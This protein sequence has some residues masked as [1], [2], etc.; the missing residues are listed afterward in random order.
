M[1]CWSVIPRTDAFARLSPFP[2]KHGTEARIFRFTRTYSFYTDVLRLNLLSVLR[3]TLASRPAWA[4][5]PAARPPLLTFRCLHCG[6]KVHQKAGTTSG[7]GS[8]R[9]NTD[10]VAK[11]KRNS[12][13]LLPPLETEMKV[14]CVAEKPSIA[15][16]LAEILNSDGFNSRPGKDKFCRNFDLKYNLGS[17]GWVDMTITSVRGHLT[18]LDFTQSYRPWSNFDPIVL[19]DAPVQVKVSKDAELISQ[20]LRLEARNAHTLMIWTDCD[21]EGEHIGAEIIRECQKANPR[22]KIKRA[23]FSA[24][25]ANQI[26]AACRNAGELDWRAAAAVEARQE[27]DLR[28]GAALTRLQTLDIKRSIPELESLISYG[29]CQFPTLGFVV[30]QYERVR[31]FVPEKFWYVLVTDK[32]REALGRPLQTVDFRWRRGHLFD[33]EI[34]KTFHNACKE[35]SDA[36]VTLVQTKPTKKFKPYPLTTVELQKSGSRLLRMAPKKI[37]DVAEKLYNRGFLSYPRTETDQYDRDF[38]FTTLIQ[39]QTQDSQWGS[40]A[41][42]LVEGLFERPRDGKKNDKAHPPIHPTAH[43]S[44]LSGDEAKV[45]E[46]V[47]R[48][49][50]G[51]CSK[52]ATGKQTTVQIEL[53]DEMFAAS[54]LVIHERNYLDVFTYDK[55]T[56]NI[57][58]EYREGETFKPHSCAMKE[59][60]TTAPNYLTEADLVNLMDKNG[61]GTDA[62]IAEHI[63]KVIDREYVTANKQGKVTYLLPSTLGQG[64]VEGYNSID[65]EKSLSKPM[66]RR[67]TEYRMNL[68]CEGQRTKEETVEESIAEYRSVYLQAKE[69]MQSLIGNVAH[70]VRDGRDSGPSLSTIARPTSGATRGNGQQPQQRESEAVVHHND[71]G[72]NG[73]HG[74]GSGGT[75]MSGPSYEVRRDTAS[76]A[77]STSLRRP[78]LGALSTNGSTAPECR[79]GDLAVART[80]VKEGPNQGRR[81]WSCAKGQSAGSC[82]FFDWVVDDAT[83]SPAIVRDGAMARSRSNSVDPNSTSRAAAATATLARRP[84]IARNSTH[85]EVPPSTR[86]GVQAMPASAE[87]IDLDLVDEDDQED[88]SWQILAS[89]SRGQQVQTQGM[90]SAAVTERQAND[91]AEIIDEL[92]M[93]GESQPERGVQ[94][95]SGAEAAAIDAYRAWFASLGEDDGGRSAPGTGPSGARNG[96]ASAQQRCDCGLEAIVRTVSKEGSNQGRQFRCCPKESNSARCKYFEWLDEVDSSDSVRGGGRGGGYNTSNPST[97]RWTVANLGSRAGTSNSS[98]ADG[99][100]NGGSNTDGND[101]CFKCGEG[102]HWASDCPF[103]GPRMG[104]ARGSNAGRPSSRG[105][106]RGAR[107]RSI[108]TTTTRKKRGGSTAAAT[109]KRRRVSRD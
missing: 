36:C 63:S 53:A 47:T 64:L 37:L 6:V 24:I 70:R 33:E 103:D 55:W 58:P 69:Q 67:E 23:R 38:N 96:V 41:Q 52:D 31:N 50:L 102:G 65:F 8:A 14:L 74:R 11:P 51:S 15:K 56:G 108:G 85:A 101:L 66:L 106:G 92:L 26:H 59:G 60:A 45:Y 73:D 19:L 4:F 39:K 107:G 82:G 84:A 46:Y 30:E 12:S 90:A 7:G 44:N 89:S 48:R 2:S 97:S 100:R 99:A 105:R 109:A 75:A 13:G 10:R 94:E 81:F 91:S 28:V 87:V 72:P 83:G 77:A 32:R 34:V 18:E 78:P 86:R 95:N 76:T 104:P 71:F 16:S 57:L 20:N 88:D 43:A 21:R 54:G 80:V 40:Y 79:C 42:S 98:R 61:I 1:G 3:A 29:P 49:F 93:M 68:I 27:L 25:I 5:V 17:M 9:T 62:T 22:L 35:A